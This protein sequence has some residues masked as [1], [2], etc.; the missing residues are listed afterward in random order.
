LGKSVNQVK[1]ANKE[2]EICMQNEDNIYMLFLGSKRRFECWEEHQSCCV[3]R[4]SLLGSG[5][6]VK[7]AHV[8]TKRGCNPVVNFPIEEMTQEPCEG[9]C[10]KI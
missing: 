1:Q 6:D 4:K 5:Y 9:C 8:P 7:E 2:K 10:E 3:R